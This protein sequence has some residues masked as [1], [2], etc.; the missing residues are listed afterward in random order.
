[1]YKVFSKEGCPWC[2]RATFALTTFNKEFVVLKLGKDFTR[3]EFMEKFGTYNHDT[4][5]AILKDGCFVGGFSELKS[6]IF[7]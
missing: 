7:S 2:S 4:F 6:E 5:P 3:E 1:M